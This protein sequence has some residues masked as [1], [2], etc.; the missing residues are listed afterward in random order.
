MAA[1]FYHNETLII[2]LLYGVMWDF[3]FLQYWPHLIAGTRS[4]PGRRWSGYFPDRFAF[5]RLLSFRP[6][7][8]LFRNRGLVGASD[9]RVATRNVL[10]G[11]LGVFVAIFVA[12]VAFALVIVLP[13]VP[14]ATFIQTAG[15][16]WQRSV[17]EAA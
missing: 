16:H 13:K 17:R 2:I 4:A 9:W 11:W 8:R 5:I 15:T 10:A 14:S 7:S 1:W 3:P 12:S 6:G